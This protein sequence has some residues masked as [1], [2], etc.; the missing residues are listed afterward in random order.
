MAMG[1]ASASTAKVKNT[2]I[3]NLFAFYYFPMK[4]VP[5][6]STNGLQWAKKKR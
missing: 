5:L 3:K 4:A 2:L 6:S 1:Q